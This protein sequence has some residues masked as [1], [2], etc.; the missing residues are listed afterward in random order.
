MEIGIQWVPGALNLGVKRR[1]VKLTTHLHLMP[2]LR[3]R[4]A[5][6]LLPQYVFTS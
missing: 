2:R 6:P 1:G 4:G 5:I 3:M